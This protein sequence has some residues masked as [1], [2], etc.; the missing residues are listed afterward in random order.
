MEKLP[1]DIAAKLD[2]ALE[3]DEHILDFRKE[4]WSLYKRNRWVVLTSKR[5]YLIK[6]VF[7]GMSFDIIQILL[8]QGHFEL[9]EGIVFDTIFIRV[10]SE[11][12]HI[13][14]FFPSERK[15][16]VDFFEKIEKAREGDPE[17]T[18]VTQAELEALAQIFY[19]KLIT[20]KEYEKKKK[21][22]LDKL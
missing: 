4:P 13:I 19:E 14:Q 21:E 2:H 17:A 9:V 16:T 5:I 7:F 20:K 12:E 15:K 11:P 18:V 22:L 3:F 1:K 8:G 10:S 6:K